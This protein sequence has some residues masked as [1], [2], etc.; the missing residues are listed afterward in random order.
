MK[1]RKLRLLNKP[2]HEPI[3]DQNEIMVGVCQTCK[4][5]VEC[6][7][8]ETK[9]DKKSIWPELSFAECPNENC[10]SRVLVSVKDPKPPE[11]PKFINVF[12]KPPRKESKDKP[13]SKDKD[14]S[15]VKMEACPECG[16]QVGVTKKDTTLED[17][18]IRSDIL[19][20][21]HFSP[22]GGWCSKSMSTL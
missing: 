16:V 17:G 12:A 22:D 14:K 5:T 20:S 6:K 3:P 11:I 2:A 9:K 18:T 7:R 1:W 10:G 19:W 21:W 8:R 13:K 4:A 15:G